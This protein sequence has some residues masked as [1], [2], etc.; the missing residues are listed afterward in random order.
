MTQE[1]PLTRRSLSGFLLLQVWLFAGFFGVVAAILVLLAV[2][3]FFFPQVGAA[4][5]GP[6][7][8][9]AALTVA[10][11]LGLAIG[12]T[13]GIQRT[14][15]LDARIQEVLAKRQKLLED[16]DREQWRRSQL[17]KSPR[18]EAP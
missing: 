4:F 3:R 13:V 5:W 1:V 9:F 12:Y 10:G 8:A 17:A 11:F 2:W 14:I 16:A 6:G 15:Y 18:Q 7:F